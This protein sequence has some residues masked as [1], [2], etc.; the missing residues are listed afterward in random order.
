MAVNV[1]EAGGARRPAWLPEAE[2]P[3]QPRFLELEG[4]RI[5]YLDEGSGP[6]LLF[7][8]AGAAW[9]FVFRDLIVRLRGQFRCVALDFPGSGLSPAAVDYW[10]GL[11]AASRVLEAFVRALDL[12]DVTLVAHDLGGPV[13]FGVAARLPERFRAMAVTESF[14]WPLSEGHPRTARLLRLTTGRPFGHLNETTNLLAR[15]TASAYGLG[16]R[17]TAAGKR[18]FRGPY[19]DRSV[20]RAAVVMLRDALLA[21]AYLRGVEGALRT[22][23]HDR[24]LLLVFGGESPQLKDGFRDRWTA[25]FPEARLLVIEGGHHFPMA[26]DPD[27]TAEAIRTWWA[28]V[29]SG[30]LATFRQGEHPADGVPVPEEVRLSRRHRRQW[31]AG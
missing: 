1:R 25:L 6:T 21:N 17:L 24:P 13:A 28:D 19:R 22:T 14:G 23:L 20:R 30:R 2:F 27:L 16:R 26:D 18:A 12:R 31:R 4:R 8:H 29:R 5:H 9:S 15:V 10:P 11:A 7:V 3:F